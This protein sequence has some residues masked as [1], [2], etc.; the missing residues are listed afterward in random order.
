M[1]EKA[2]QILQ[3]SFGYTSFRDRQ[4]E[5]IKAVLEGRD[6]LAIMP[7][8]GGK[9]LCYQIP[10]LV[11]D[12]LSII[13]SPL[14]ALMKDQVDALRLNGIEA[15]FIN[16]TQST[17]E[18]AQILRDVKAGKIKLLYCAPERLIGGNNPL[19]QWIKEFNPC[20]FAIDEAHCISQWGHDF[21]PE[22]LE[23]GQIA[24]EFPKVPI[25]ALTATADKLTRQDILSKLGLRNPGVFISSFNRK[26]ISYTVEPKLQSFGRLMDFLREHDNDSGIVYCLSRKSVEDVAERL[27]EEGINALPYHAGLDQQTRQKNQELFQNDQVQ[28][29]VA[30]IAFGMGIDKSNVRFVVHM[31]LPKNLE[32]YYQE[33]G[34]AGRDGLPSEA[35]LFFSFGDVQKLQRFIQV[36]GNSKQTK[37]LEKK[38]KQMVDYCQVDY[39]RRQYLMNYFDE[40]FPDYCGSCDV[41]LS[42]FDLEDATENAQ[43]ALSAVARLEQNYGINYVIDFLKG[44]KSKKI[45]ERHKTLK[46]Y[47]I[48]DHMTKESWQLFFKQLL[49]DEL[50]VQNGIEMPVLALTDK[51]WEV[52]KGLKPYQIKRV[53]SRASVSKTGVEPMDQSLFEQLRIVRRK[54]AERDQVPPYVVLSD[55]SLQELATYRPHSE[56]DLLR[57]SGFGNI[58]VER[59]GKDF[60]EVIRLYCQEHKLKS[61]IHYKQGSNPKKATRSTETKE[62]SFELYQQ[63]KSVEEIAE[64]RSLAITTVMSHLASYVSRGIIPIES[65]VDPNTQAIIMKAIGQFGTASLKILKENLPD[66]ISYGEIRMVIAKSESIKV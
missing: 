23:L 29:M 54:L 21:R 55:A 30:T 10:A 34:R 53:K 63:G 14:I 42:K 38:L 15:A 41:C 18:Q 56:D 40:V 7:T 66:T 35:L 19:L 37:I 32:S 3:Q 60:L 13:I 48:G 59:Y 52:L 4:E 49:R 5:I 17:A 27:R 24:T 12:G 28:I 46:T 33:T 31:D 36:D 62:K 2:K 44:S 26:N 1:I 57:I 6:C 43:K 8:G 64:I 50:L 22:Y 65:F 61:R 25:I 51:S 58:K 47:G 45:L 39:C 16:S 20:L 11:F 9:S